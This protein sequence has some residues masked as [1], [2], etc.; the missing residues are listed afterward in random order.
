MLD[1]RQKL[2]YNIVVLPRAFAEPHPHVCAKNF[3]FRGSCGSLTGKTPSR[4]EE[5]MPVQVRLAVL[6]MN[7]CLGAKKPSPEMSGEGFFR[8]LQS[9]GLFS[10]AA[11][12]QAFIHTHL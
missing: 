3:F 1:I 11:G 9:K 8:L 6:F 10:V 5:N 4:Q 7:T 12:E 2:C